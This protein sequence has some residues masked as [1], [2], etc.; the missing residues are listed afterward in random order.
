ME[1]D[2]AQHY[3]EEGKTLEEEIEM[4]NCTS[5]TDFSV[6]NIQFIFL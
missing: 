4:T 3:Q 2:E 6:I 1:V 5:D